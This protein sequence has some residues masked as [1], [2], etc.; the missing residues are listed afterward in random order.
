MGLVEI[1]MLLVY[2]TVSR[3]DVKCISRRDP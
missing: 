1:C 3:L 2:Y